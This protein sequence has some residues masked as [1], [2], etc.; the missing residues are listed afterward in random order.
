M[1]EDIEPQHPRTALLS[2]VPYL[3]LNFAGRAVLDKRPF[4]LGAG[5][6][7]CCK[8]RPLPNQGAAFS[9]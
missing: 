1:L 4:V 3:W 7:L 8:P 5:Y 9:L 6:L 2:D